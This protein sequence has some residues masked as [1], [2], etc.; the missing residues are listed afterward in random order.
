MLGYAKSE[1]KNA[2]SAYMLTPVWN[3]YGQYMEQDGN[4]YSSSTPLMSIDAT[5]GSIV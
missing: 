1:I 2:N 5:D 4:W 3:F